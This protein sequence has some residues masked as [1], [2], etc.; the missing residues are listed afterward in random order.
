ML[1]PV[2]AYAALEPLQNRLLRAGAVANGLPAREEL[3]REI[4]GGTLRAGDFPGALLLLHRREGFDRLHFMLAKGAAFPDWTPEVR[5]VVEIAFRAS[6]TALR[7]MDRLLAQRGFAPVLTRV[8]LTR[9]PGEVAQPPPGAAPAGTGQLEQAEEILQACFSPL[10]GC[11]P[12]RE[13]LREAL[14]QGRVLSCPGGVL[15]YTPRGA[16]TE[17]RHLAVSATCRGQG[18]GRLLLGTYLARWGVRTSRV[19]TGSD[20]AAALALYR[21]AGYIE[22]GWRSCVRVYEPGGAGPY[23]M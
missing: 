12:L 9:R 18:L 3:E 2:T 13:E 20:N 19:W 6:D 21:G 15:H 10:T 23:E 5:T 1:T 17:I 8:R 7:G 14:E 11:L 16:G 22:D 4:R